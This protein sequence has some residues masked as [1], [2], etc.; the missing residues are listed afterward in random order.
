MLVYFIVAC[1]RQKITCCTFLGK[2]KINNHKD[3]QSLN[4]SGKICKDSQDMMIASIVYCLPSQLI[5]WEDTGERWICRL[6]FLCRTKMYCHWRALYNLEL[7]LRT[8]I[9][10]ARWHHHIVFKIAF[11]AEIAVTLRIYRHIKRHDT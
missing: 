5:V 9:H 8:L 2:K 11:R 10:Q 1:L 7:E 3:Y 6:S 4:Q